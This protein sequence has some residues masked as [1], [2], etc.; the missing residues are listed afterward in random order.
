MS[1][2]LLMRTDTPEAE[3]YLYGVDGELI[4]EHCWHAHRTLARD[5]LV[6]IETVCNE[7]EREW[8]D[9]AGVGVWSGPGSFTGLRIG[10]TVANTIAHIQKCPIIGVTGDS[11]REDAIAALQRDEVQ[12]VVMPEYGAVPHITQPKK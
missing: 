2:Y 7:A 5:I 9:I 10:V 12:Q 3:V 6:T 8:S 4:A 1:G 11:W